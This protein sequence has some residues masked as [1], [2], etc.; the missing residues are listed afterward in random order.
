MNISSPHRN[1][2]KI[3]LWKTRNETEEKSWKLSKKKRTTIKG[4]EKT[5]S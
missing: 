1:E 4:S 2:N 5:G 3:S